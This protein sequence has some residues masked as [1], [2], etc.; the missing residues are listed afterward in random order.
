MAVFRNVSFSCDFELKVVDHLLL[1]KSKSEKNFLVRSSGC[2]VPL[3]QAQLDS[4]RDNAVQVLVAKVDLKLYLTDVEN[5][6]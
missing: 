4:Y 5:I 3:A 1:G 6:F 2:Y